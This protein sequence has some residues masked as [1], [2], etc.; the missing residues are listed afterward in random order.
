MRAG[1]RGRREDR[2]RGESKRK[3]E[4]M[5]ES[6]SLMLSVPYRCVPIR[7]IASNPVDGGNNIYFSDTF[8]FVRY[9]VP[10]VLYGI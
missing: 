3:R 6:N 7:A 2:D 1:G 5:R 8:C 9:N 4:V 10:N